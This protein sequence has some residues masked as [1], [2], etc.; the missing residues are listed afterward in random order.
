MMGPLK[1]SGEE[2]ASESCVV[3]TR[4]FDRMNEEEEVNEEVGFSE[5][6]RGVR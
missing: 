2:E 4:H 5:F 6:L 3:K 1:G